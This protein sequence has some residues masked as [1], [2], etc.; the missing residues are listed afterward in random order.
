[1]NT[2]S[3][4]KCRI[5]TVSRTSIVFSGAP[6]QPPRRERLPIGVLDRPDDDC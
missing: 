3:L 1:L 6:P 2:S 5:C 4:T